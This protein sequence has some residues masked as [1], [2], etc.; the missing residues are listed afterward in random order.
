MTADTSLGKISCKHYTNYPLLIQLIKENKETFTDE[1]KLNN[2][3]ELSVEV[4]CSLAF[5]NT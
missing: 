3:L 5:L 4:Y 1:V 2:T